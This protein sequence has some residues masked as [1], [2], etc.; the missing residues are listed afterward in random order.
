MKNIT[1]TVSSRQ[2]D[3]V[4]KVRKLHLR[5]YVV[6]VIE[7]YNTNLESMF[8]LLTL[9]LTALKA[10]EIPKFDS[11]ICPSFHVV[12]GLIFHKVSLDQLLLLNDPETIRVLGVYNF[13]ISPSFVL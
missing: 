5:N 2:T 8:I 10:L 7:P 13:N 1:R 3:D 6:E 12:L 11:E 9:R 4:L